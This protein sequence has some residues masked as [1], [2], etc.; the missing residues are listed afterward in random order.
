MTTRVRVCAL[1]EL[2]VG[3]ALGV[4]VE[5]R[6]ICLARCADGVR[7]IADLCSHE[8]YNLSDGEV[9]PETCEIECW[10]HGSVFSLVTGEPQNLPATRPVATYAVEIVG[11][12]VHVVLP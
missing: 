1:E 8:D 10:A 6:E 12:D 11:D 2:K 5:G 3:A 7:A 4:V 9:D